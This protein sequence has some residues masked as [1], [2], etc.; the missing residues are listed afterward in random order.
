MK[1]TNNNK[2]IKISLIVIVVLFLIYFSK[3]AL[4]SGMNDAKQTKQQEQKGNQ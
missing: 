1:T 4:L 3:T 2:I